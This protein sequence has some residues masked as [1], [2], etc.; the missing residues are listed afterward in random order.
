LYQWPAHFPTNCPPISA[1]EASGLLFRFI[2]RRQPVV[3]DFQSHFERDSDKDWSPN[4]CQA[5]GLSVLKTYNDC[6]TMRAN[7][8]ALRKKCLA[9]GTLPPSAG[10]IAITPSNNCDEH[11]T[12]WRWISPE[13]AL[14]LFSYFPE[15]G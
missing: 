5:R 3:R 8:P 9:Q 6:Q 4:D 7:V 15:A 13:S 12:W 2:N 14:A 11:H 10:L 1:V